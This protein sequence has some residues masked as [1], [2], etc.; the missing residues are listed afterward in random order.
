MEYVIDAIDDHVSSPLLRF[1]LESIAVGVRWTVTFLVFL[2]VWH[3]LDVHRRFG[4][5]HVSE[6]KVHFYSAIKNW[7]VYFLWGIGLRWICAVFGLN[8]YEMSLEH[9]A[10]TIDFAVDPKYVVLTSPN[11]ATDIAIAVFFFYLIDFADWFAHW[12]N[13]RYEFLYWRFPFAHITH[14]NMIFLNPMAVASSPFFHFAQVSG[15]FIYVFLL[16]QGLVKPMLYIHAAKMF[17]N[18][19]SHLGC[20]PLPWLTILNH[21]VGGWIP[22][23]PLHHQYHHLPF[24]KRG[25]YGNI[26]VVW[27]Y[28]FGTLIP[29][30]TYHIENGKPTEKVQAKISEERVIARSVRVLY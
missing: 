11:T 29:E 10:P 5:F 19:I 18:F 9:F 28:V 14:H 27:D 22:W 3:Y 15:C 1:S 8:L 4:L 30:C 21:K 16:S 20:D 12:F 6:P 7:K 13:H 2:F 17:S 25:N 23:I 24:V 26:T